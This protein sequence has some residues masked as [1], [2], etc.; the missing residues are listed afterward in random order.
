MDVIT[1]RAN[2][3]VN[4][5]LDV[6]E[7]R[8]DGYHNIQ[9]VFQFVSLCDKLELKKS[10][11]NSFWC[12][13]KSLEGPENL[14]VKA[15]R[16]LAEEYPITPVGIR[17]EKRIPCMSGLGGGSADAAAVLKGLNQLFELNISP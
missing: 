5:F 8:P 12:S 4:L 15:W 10:D 16:R 1:L 11:R 6:L 7:R 13:D 2:A 17:L 3:K 14:A 9:S